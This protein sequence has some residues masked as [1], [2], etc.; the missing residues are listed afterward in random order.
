MEGLEAA[1]APRRGLGRLVEDGE[2]QARA[3]L[4]ASAAPQGF[5]ASAANPHYAALWTRDVA[6]SSMGANV[7][8]D[9]ALVE[10]VRRSL[11]TL[12]GIQAANGQIPNDYWPGRG[13]W[14]FHESG[15][16]DATCL[17]AVAAAQHL[18]A[19]PNR[20]L[21]AQLWP[22]IERA[23]AWLATQDANHFSL[24]D[25]P[26]G[27]DW[28]DSTLQRSGKLLYV[29][30]LY[31]RALRGAGEL[32]PTAAARRAYTQQAELVRRKINAYFWPEPG[33]DYAQMLEGIP[34][35]KGAEVRFPHPVGPAAHRAAARRNRSFYLSHVEG[36]R[37][38]DEC[39]VLGNVLAVL[40][41]VA[42]G[43]R[44]ERIMRFLH[45]GAAAK[46][47]PARS[48]AQAL[49]YGDRWGMLKQDLDAL[50]D[51]RWRNPPNTYHNAG[52]WPFIGG[53]YVVAL[54]K[55]GMH[56]DAETAMR[57]LAAA[58]RLGGTGTSW[59]FHEWVNSATGEVGGASGQ[60]W[61]AGTYL[62]ACHALRGGA[63]HL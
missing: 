17:F 53:L 20:K 1:A 29:N 38:V 54:E 33:D 60:T 56:R 25:S 34:Y 43:P 36:E 9:A 12:A 40:F 55:V 11:L 8:G 48:Y 18:A 62:L 4:H 42:D 47:Y 45:R 7:S 31:H 27:G 6:F 22:H 41:G 63:T 58:N 59:G 44:A 51:P 28:M 21:Q 32:A 49:P 26:M 23:C 13:Y 39:D 2:L 24:I 30:V 37:R 10:T 5:V 35:P 50:Q 3:V 46:P 14:D 61:S 52:V 19:H 16:T 57:K 15:S